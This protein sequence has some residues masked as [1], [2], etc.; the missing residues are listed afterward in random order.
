VTNVALTPAVR[1]WTVADLDRFPDDGLHYEI[2]EGELFVSRAP[3]NDHQEVCNL[4]ATPL[5]VWNQE[6]RLGHVL[7][8]V[9]V[10]FSATDSVI[11]DIVWVSRERRAAI[12]GADRHLHGAPEL[13]VEVLSLGAANEWRDRE[14]KLKL[15]SRYGVEEYWIIDWRAKTVAVYRRSEGE[16]G[17]AQLL[18][19]EDVLTSPLLP[20]FALPVAQLF[21]SD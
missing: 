15:Y 19:R 6:T 1:C 4:C 7:P 14:A 3:G 16:L 5:T 12:E 9:G 17:L 20:G 8:G 2:L 18:R 11:P 10:I 21:A 13:V